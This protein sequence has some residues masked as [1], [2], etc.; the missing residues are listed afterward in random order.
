MYVLTTLSF[1]ELESRESRAGPVVPDIFTV[2]P[3]FLVFNNSGIPDLV[4]NT[5]YFNNDPHILNPT[6]HF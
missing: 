4:L 6:I 5:E 3:G 2:L 1:L